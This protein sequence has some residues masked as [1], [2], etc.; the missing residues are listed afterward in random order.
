MPGRICTRFVHIR[1][2][3]EAGGHAAIMGALNLGG[4]VRWLISIEHLAPIWGGVCNGLHDLLAHK[5]TPLALTN[6]VACDLRGPQGP[7]N[8]K[9]YF[10]PTTADWSPKNLLLKFE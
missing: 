7:Q 4:F 9:L 2:L 5:K 8:Q 1:P 10:K 6:G 3:L